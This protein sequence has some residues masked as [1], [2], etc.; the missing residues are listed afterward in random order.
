MAPESENYWLRLNRQGGSFAENTQLYRANTMILVLEE[1]KT[2]E[3]GDSYKRAR[4]S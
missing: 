3:N 4:R 1:I 2:I